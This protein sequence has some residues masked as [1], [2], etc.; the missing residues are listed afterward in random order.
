M[1]HPSLLR[2]VSLLQ[3]QVA[4][5]DFFCQFLFSIV[6]LLIHIW[7]KLIDF[8]DG[9][10]RWRID[11]LAVPAGV[12]GRRI[13]LLFLAQVANKHVM[14]PS[15]HPRVVSVSKC[16]KLLLWRLL[17][18]QFFKVTVHLQH[19]AFEKTMLN[20]G[21]RFEQHGGSAR[22]VSCDVIRILHQEVFLVFLWLASVLVGFLLYN[23]TGWAV[24]KRKAQPSNPT[25]WIELKLNTLKM[26]MNNSVSSVVR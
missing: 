7:T 2:R 12:V 20:F 6:F 25:A 26:A 22:R 8:V 23:H 17:F 5:L 15:L 9:C 24:E 21:G 10:C 19:L 18:L 16:M 13:T 11:P 1:I 14:R 4:Q 3:L